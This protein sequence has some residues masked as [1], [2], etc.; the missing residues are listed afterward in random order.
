MKKKKNK[1]HIYFSDFFGVS[2]ATMKAY[3]AFN[4]SL[5]NDLPMFIDPFL[6]FNSNK[7]EYKQLHKEMIDY[8]MFLR[9]RSNGSTLDPGAMKALYLFREVRQNWLGY[10]V[11]GNDG[12]GLGKKFAH[13]LHQNFNSTF[14]DFGEEDVPQ[15]P[16]FEKLTL[17]DSGIG[18]DNVSDFTTNLIKRF[19][20][21]FTQDFA[22]QYLDPAFLKKVPVKRA[23][24]N[25]ETETW[26]S[27]TYT[28]PWFVDDY[29]LLT[30]QDILMKDELWINRRD[31]VGDY[32]EIVESIA[33]D[34]L[35]AQINNYFS[36]EIGLILQKKEQQVREKLAR[37]RRSSKPII[38]PPIEPTQKE[39]AQVKWMAVQQFPEIVDYYLR[40]KE[41]NGDKAV[42]QSQANL[43]EIR[44]R[45]IQGVEQL[46]ELL[47]KTTDF[48]SEPEDSYDAAMQRVMYLKDVIE[49][50]DGWKVFYVNGQPF[51]RE[52]D[53]HILFRL[54]WFASSFDV[55]T[56][57]NSGRGPVDFSI[58]K[59]SANKSLVEFKL[60]SNSQ[61]ANNLEH[62]TE[63]YKMAHRTKKS[64]TVVVYYKENELGRVKAILRQLGLEKDK[65]IVLIDA[66][67]DNKQSASKVKTQ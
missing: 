19:L 15:S 51:T 48:Y 57:A 40:L 49:N 62:Q 6:L 21:E 37:K 2:P 28:L 26:A 11:N 54:T 9:D 36:K 63:V 7:A 41:K 46:V 64:I 3:G 38:L 17:F 14:K 30:P 4:I 52:R 50:N 59:G 44:N 10:S 35:R 23:Q 42:E 8:L 55:Q 25:Y 66:R 33:N 67:N 5:I 12:R 29:V 34:Q 53:V 18:K 61:L 24:F 56:E 13:A 1:I 43:E 20:L 27:K 22:L 45:F 65:N 60:A 47:N 32:D 39:L 58:S 16:H 31:L